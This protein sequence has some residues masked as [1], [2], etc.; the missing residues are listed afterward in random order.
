VPVGKKVVQLPIRAKIERRRKENNIWGRRR[1]RGRGENERK[2]L[3]KEEV[4][5]VGPSLMKI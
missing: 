1:S 5:V 4:A 3:K 2:G